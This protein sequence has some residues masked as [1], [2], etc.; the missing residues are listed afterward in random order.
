MKQ[1]IMIGFL[2]YGIATGFLSYWW[3]NVSDNIFYLNIPGDL[4]GQYIYEQS[5]VVLG[6]P[7]SAQA[8]YTIPW[9]LRVPQI[10]IPTSIIIWGL[11]G[12]IIQFAFN[13]ARKRFT[14]SVT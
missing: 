3:W 1:K 13:Q 10:Y 11:F 2:I 12:C 14:K 6:S 8:H 4:L 5:I 9:I 7:D